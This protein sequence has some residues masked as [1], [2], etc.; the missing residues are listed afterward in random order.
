MFCL[1]AHF[2]WLDYLKNWEVRLSQGWSDL[3]LASRSCECDISG[4]PWG[5]FR[6]ELDSRMNWLDCG[7]QSQGHCDPRKHSFGINSRIQF[8][9]NDDISQKC[10]IGWRSNELIMTSSCPAN[11]FLGSLFITTAQEQ[12]RGGFT[13]AGS[14]EGRRE[15][16]SARE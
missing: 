11:R 8:I 2:L 4:T 6:I 14:H 12:Q 16:C 15:I 1:S 10:P 13:E 3:S 7:S 5:N 9:S